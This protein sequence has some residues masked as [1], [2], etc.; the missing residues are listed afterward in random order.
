MEMKAEA[1]M[2]VGQLKERNSSGAGPSVINPPATD[3]AASETPVSIYCVPITMKASFSICILIALLD[4][5][6][7]LQ[8]EVC[9]GPGASCTGDLQTCAVGADTCSISLSESTL[10][11]MKQ[12]I[13]IKGCATSSHCTAGPVTMNFGNGVAIRSSI[14]CCMGDAC[15]T[16]T[17]T[18]PPADP[19]PN[20]QRCPACISVL[21]AQCNEET[22]QCTGSDTQCI[23]VAGTVT[24]GGTSTVTTMKGCAS[25]TACA[26]FKGISG[27]LEG[28]S[29]ALSVVKCKAPGPAPGPV[30]LLI[31]ALAGLLLQK[32][33]I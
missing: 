12:Q 28:V 33:L 1:S 6:A 13:I 29:A 32:L 8:C 19:K 24:F 4:R 22:I 9:S 23:E 25:E 7:C 15:R 21:Y 3:L 30:G 18:V 14:A 11:G 10:V 16:T 2:P 26:R 20:G 17:V 5:G 31:P 27:T